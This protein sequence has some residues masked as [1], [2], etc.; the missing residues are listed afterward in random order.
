MSI[1]PASAVRFAY[2]IPAISPWFTSRQLETLELGFAA[3]QRG[4]PTDTVATEKGFHWQLREPFDLHLRVSSNE[5][6]GLA[7]IQ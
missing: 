7:E 3:A 6:H 5:P 4:A 2:R 1:R